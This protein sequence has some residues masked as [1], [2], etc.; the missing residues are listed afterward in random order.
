ML[1]ISCSKLCDKNSTYQQADL[2]A[3]QKN[4]A[5]NKAE[6]VMFK[7]KEKFGN[8]SIGFGNMLDSDL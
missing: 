8:T 3:E 1:G 7:I 2:F 6:D 5:D 4:N